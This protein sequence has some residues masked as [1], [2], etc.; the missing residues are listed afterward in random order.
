MGS[1]RR[2]GN[3]DKSR[4]AKDLG[5]SFAVFF[6]FIYAENIFCDDYFKIYYTNKYI[7][8]PGCFSS[9]KDHSIAELA[10]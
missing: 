2:V 1:P 9:C 8:V 6:G 3:E 10:D 7:C 4:R 5:L